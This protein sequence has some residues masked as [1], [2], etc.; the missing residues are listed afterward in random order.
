MIGAFLSLAALAHSFALKQ[1][2]TGVEV[3][4]VDFWDIGRNRWWLGSCWSLVRVSYI[5]WQMLRSGQM[6]SKRLYGSCGCLGMVVG[7]KIQVPSVGL[8]Y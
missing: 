7:W 3:V 6:L 8:L 4:L 2:V 1:Q 5:D